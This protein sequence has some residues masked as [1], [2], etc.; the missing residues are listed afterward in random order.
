MNIKRH[1]AAI[2]GIIA[3]AAIAA[4]VAVRSEEICGVVIFVIAIVAMGAAGWL[5]IG[6]EEE[7]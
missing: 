2:M 7:T 4:G 6:S 5:A 3:C 1:G